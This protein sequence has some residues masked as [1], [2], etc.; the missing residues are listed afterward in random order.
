MDQFVGSAIW[1]ERRSWPPGNSLHIYLLE[2]VQQVGSALQPEWSGT[3]GLPPRTEARRA[4][5]IEE[6]RLGSLTKSF[7]KPAQFTPEEAAG[8]EALTSLE[9]KEKTAALKA[10]ERLA[11]VVEWIRLR[12]SDGSIPCNMMR[13]GG[14]DYV[15]APSEIWNQHPVF[16]KLFRTGSVRRWRLSYVGSGG[17]DFWLFLDRAALEQQ[18][19]RTIS[20]AI[21]KAGTPA[22]IQSS[23]SGS[24]S[25]DA[26][27]CGRAKTL[28]SQRRGKKS[29]PKPKW[30]DELRKLFDKQHEALSGMSQRERH[31]HIT[32]FLVSS[33]GCPRSYSTTARHWDAHLER[34]ARNLR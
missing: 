5:I 20:P 2:A 29:G 25:P 30:A 28:P 11:D 17:S 34:R 3:E 18:L 19:Q 4:R 1:A 8:L 15:E 27:Q 16:E 12:C 24:P 9:T 32:K 23:S 13:V 21:H 22:V 26:V 33:V 7:R 10:T 31:D 14:G 6:V